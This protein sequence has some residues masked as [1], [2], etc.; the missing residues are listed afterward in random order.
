MTPLLLI[1]GHMCD[2]RMWGPQ[3]AAFAHRPIHLAEIAGAETVEALAASVL[4]S[5][6]PTFALAG[7]SM[8]GIV[9]MEVARQAPGRVERLALLDTNPLPEA[10]AVKAERRA[11]MARVAEGRLAEVVREEMKPLYLAPGPGKGAIMDLCHDMAVGLGPEVFRRQSLA[12]MSRPDQRE[13]LR[14]LRVPALIL[15]GAED[16]LVPFERHGLMAGLMPQARL[17]VVEG[18]GHLP[19]LENPAA[20]DAAL[21]EWLA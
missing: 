18:A 11:R 14:S 12:L 17:V 16:R 15:T 8:G 7:L 10:E 2:G 21:R 9:A 1:P 13:T 19:V 5:A 4:A 20:T 3:L 6:P